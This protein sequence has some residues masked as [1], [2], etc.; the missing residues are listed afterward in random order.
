MTWAD[1][2]V[3]WLRAPLGVHEDDS[4][5]VRGYVNRLGRK[6]VMYEWREMSD[7]AANQHVRRDAQTISLSASQPL[8]VRTIYAAAGPE[9]VQEV[10]FMPFV[11]ATVTA[12][13]TMA[14]HLVVQKRGGGAGTYS[15]TYSV[16]T[17]VAGISSGTDKA[18]T[19]SN[20]WS[21]LT[22][23]VAHGV[24]PCHL[25]ST[26]ASLQLKKGDVLTAQVLKGSGAGADSG[27]IFRGGHIKLVIDEDD[28]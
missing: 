7:T 25:N 26:G 24:N 21:T 14:Y 5:T 2:K 17:Y 13:E 19:H 28:V 16:T 11:S 9:K 12:T 18:G 10:L 1:F 27:A 22:Q 8:A 6:E 3:R 15:T 20:S 4:N 23:N